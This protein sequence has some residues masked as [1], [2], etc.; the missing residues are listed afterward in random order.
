MRRVWYE[1]FRRRGGWKAEIGDD[2]RDHDPPEVVV[3]CPECW[4]REFGNAASRGS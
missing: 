4:E 1:R 3:F 2:L